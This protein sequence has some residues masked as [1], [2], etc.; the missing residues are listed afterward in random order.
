MRKTIL[1]LAG[2]LALGAASTLHAQAV[3]FTPV[4]TAAQITAVTGQSQFFPYGLDVD[5]SGR[6]YVIDGGPAGGSADD[7][8]LRITPG[9]PPTIEIVA[10]GAQMFAALDAANGTSTA[11]DFNA[12]QLAIAA[13]GDIIILGFTATFGN[14]DALLSINPTSLPGTVSVVY[15]PTD[16]NNSAIDGAG[17][18]TVV[19]NTAYVGTDRSNGSICNLW[20]IDTNSGSAPAAPVTALVTETDL[21][22]FYAG[23]SQT[24]AAAD[25]ALNDVT[26]DGTD[27][28]AIVSAT[29]PATDDVLRITTAGAISRIFSGPQLV[30]ALAVLD[31]NTTDTGYNALA[32]DGEGVVWLSNRFGIAASVYDDSIVVVSGTGASIDVSRSITKTALQTQLGTTALP[33]VNNDAMAYDAV[34]NRVV[35]GERGSTAGERGIFA[36]PAT[37]P[38]ASV[39]EWSLY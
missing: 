14:G 6:I 26:T 36:S 11:T 29:T 33:F 32:V 16:A 38:T 30:S 21:I 23:L 28:I 5:S 12:R 13:D 31:A 2:T 18:L 25:V 3:N 15:T 27:I 1:T 4:A 17:A 9:S 24:V 22:N 7:A 19:G 37:T 8:I 35:F 34:N 39:F 10:T 20:A